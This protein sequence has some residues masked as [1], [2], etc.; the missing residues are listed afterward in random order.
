MCLQAVRTACRRAYV[1]QVPAKT[2]P[3]RL[4]WVS[5][6]L[7]VGQFLDLY[8]L[9]MP[10][11]HHDRP[12]IGWPELGPPLLMLGVLALYISH[13]LKRHLP[14]AVGDPL[15]EESQRFYL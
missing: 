3:I 14:L 10:Q 6:L 8:W 4:V 1:F 15:L 12:V 11:I 9:I 2:N 13:F 5:I 7:L